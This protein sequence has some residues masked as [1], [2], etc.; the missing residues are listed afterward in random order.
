MNTVICFSRLVPMDLLPV[1]EVTKVGSI[2]T[3][4]LSQSVT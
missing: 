1:E 4:Y 2:S 3:L